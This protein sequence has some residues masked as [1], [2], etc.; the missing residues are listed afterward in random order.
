MQ[1]VLE[2]SCQS[3]KKSDNIWEKYTPWEIS[4]IWL[5]TYISKWLLW[6]KKSSF[7]AIIKANQSDGSTGQKDSF[8]IIALWPLSSRPTHF[9]KNTLK[10]ENGR[11]LQQSVIFLTKLKDLPSSQGVMSRGKMR[12]L[13]RRKRTRSYSDTEI[14]PRQEELPAKSGYWWEW[15]RGNLLLSC[16]ASKNK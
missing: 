3:C 11:V 15:S 9:V 4:P 2:N 14:K 6:F 7:K 1:E 8:T 13:W 16:S 5:W 10:A 12:V